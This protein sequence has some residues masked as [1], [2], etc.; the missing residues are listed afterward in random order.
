MNWTAI[1]AIADLL[2]SIG[3]IV[4]LIY[5]AIQLRLNSKTV[6][7]SN[8]QHNM[9]AVADMSAVIASDAEL[10]DIYL[11]GCESFSRLGPQEQTRFHMVMSNFILPIQH[12]VHMQSRGLTDSKLYEGEIES[13]LPLFD[14]PGVM[15]WWQAGAT[16]WYHQDFVAHLNA[17]IA[18][19]K[20]A[21]SV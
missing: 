10:A 21:L 17:L 7:T 3:V 6:G 20:N 15:E 13:F 14:Q 5:V 9:S 18:E 19:R 12:N 4:S 1:S 2:A 16:R 11:R 8:Y